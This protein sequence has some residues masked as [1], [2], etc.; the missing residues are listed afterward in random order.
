[1]VIVH[2]LIGDIDDELMMTIGVFSLDTC[3]M[4]GL[5]AGLTVQQKDNLLFSQWFSHSEFPTKGKYLDITRKRKKVLW[6]V[7]APGGLI[8]A[9]NQ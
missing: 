1:M 9:R 7:R 5:S 3:C 8:Q 6:S 2:T 4:I